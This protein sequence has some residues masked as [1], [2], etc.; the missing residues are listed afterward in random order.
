MVD[1]INV[2]DKI[3]LFQ[4]TKTLVLYLIDRVKNQPHDL[5]LTPMLLRRVWRAAINCPGF[6]QVN[7]DEIVFYAEVHPQI[8]LELGVVPYADRWQCLWTIGPKP[9]CPLDLL[10][11]SDTQPVR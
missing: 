9:G 5:H 6:T 4:T 1:Y 3:R 10:M 2:Q 8:A 11:V 7:K